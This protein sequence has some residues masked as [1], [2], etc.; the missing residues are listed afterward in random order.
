MKRIQPKKR[1][2]YRTVRFRL[3]SKEIIPVRA[4][5]RTADMLEE[6]TKDMS[7]YH[8]VR[9]AQVLEAVYNQGRKDGAAEA[10]GALDRAQREVKKLI[11]HKKPGRPKSS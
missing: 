7:L 2:G 8:G 9:F 1:R 5:A 10:F 11:P 3:A 6:I 4:S